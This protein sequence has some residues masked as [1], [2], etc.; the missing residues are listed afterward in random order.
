MGPLSEHERNMLLDL[1]MSLL[2]DTRDPV[3][4]IVR[5]TYARAPR[6][7]LWGGAVFVLE[8]IV[9]TVFLTEALVVSMA[10]L[11]IAVGSSLVC[12][13]QCLTAWRA[14]RMLGDR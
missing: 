12:A 14:S 10:G 4:L 7:A 5:C 9:M 6:R 11:L 3:D 13:H 8:V 1:E 2:T